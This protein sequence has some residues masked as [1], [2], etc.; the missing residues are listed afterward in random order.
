MLFAMLAWVLRFGLFAYGDPGPNLWMIIL[1]CIIS[2]EWLFDFLFQVPLYRNFTDANIRSK[3]Q[4][5]FMMM[6]NGIGAF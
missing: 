1:S 6:S 2:M 4:G 3:R 5:L